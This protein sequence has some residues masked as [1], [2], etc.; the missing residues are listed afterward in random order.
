VRA[1]AVAV[2]YGIL[3]V[4]LGWLVRAF[5]ITTALVLT[6]ATFGLFSFLFG[7]VNVLVNAVLL[8]LTARFFTAFRLDGWVPAFVLGL[9]IAAA[10]LLLQVVFN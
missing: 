6:V 1:V 9:L 8:R 10:Q 2:V 7:L 5:M 3:N 4:L